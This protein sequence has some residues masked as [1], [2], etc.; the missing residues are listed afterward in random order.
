MHQFASWLV[1]TRQWLPPHMQAVSH[2]KHHWSTN[3]ICR[4]CLFDSLL[5]ENIFEPVQPHL[6]NHS[7]DVWLCHW[8][9]VRSHACMRSALIHR[10]CTKMFFA[11]VHPTPSGWTVLKWAASLSNPINLHCLPTHIDDLP[12]QVNGMM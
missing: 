7:Q 4:K 1:S 3:V 9:A 5:L 10:S 6:R 8:L 11:C 2:L 12:F